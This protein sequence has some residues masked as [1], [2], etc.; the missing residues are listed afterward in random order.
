LVDCPATDFGK[1]H[2]P[3]QPQF[4]DDSWN[5]QERRHGVK[6]KFLRLTNFPALTIH[7]H[8]PCGLRSIR[9][10]I[11]AA[12]AVRAFNLPNARSTIRLPRPD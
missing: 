8:F 6:N 1:P 12:G 2:R 11:G 4:R 3:R 5:L 10:M 9:G 7:A